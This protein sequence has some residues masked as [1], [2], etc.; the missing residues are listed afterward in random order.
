[1][2]VLLTSWSWPTHYNWLV[3]VAWAFRSAGHEVLV[4]V[5]PGGTHGVTRAGLPAVAVG[6]DFDVDRV[7][8]KYYWSSPI[9]EISARGD[10]VDWDRMR[11][12]GQ[13][14]LAVYAL[15][16]SIMQD[17]LVA[18]T[19]GWR[20]DLMVFDGVNYA[21]PL[22]AAA[23]GI[24][25]VRQIWGVDFSSQLAPFADE[26]L[27][28]HRAQ[29]G[30]GEVDVL[31]TATLDPCPPSMQLVDGV[32]RLPTRYPSYNGP[33]KAPRWVL[34][35]PR[36]PRVCVTWGTVSH[37]FNGRIFPLG[38]ALD[39]LADLDVEVVATV[40]KGGRKELGSV[41]ANTRVVEDL[42]LHLFMASCDLVISQ[43]GG[44]VTATAVEA[45]VPQLTVP[46][47]S[48]QVLI[49]R[50][51]ER[52]GA[53][54]MIALDDASTALLR[55]EVVRLLGSA[56]HTAAARSLMREARAQ[57]SLADTVDTLTALAG[58]A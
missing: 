24:P 5:P 46:R 34:D 36:R 8:S 11:E 37:L 18:L 40:P 49:C 10:D 30:L 3:P 28:R 38:G 21:A 48:E 17:G 22:A 12:E 19:R 44:G 58:R 47:T 39:A 4:A 15:L 50:S 14:P 32:R 27:A 26:A 16:A 43:G 41:P 6:A 53:A 2:R 55:E 33:G 13:Q 20:P 57:R 9:A 52:T 42:P 45:G 23:C 1:M 25:A 56:A 7:I 51:L 35:R 54:R 29:L 31:G